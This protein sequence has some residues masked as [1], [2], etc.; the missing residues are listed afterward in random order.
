MFALTREPIDPRRVEAAV[1]DH[2]FGG[3]VAFFGVVRERSSDGRP[4]TGL[5]Y[6][7][8]EPMALAEFAAIARETQRFGEIRLAIVHRLGELRVGD[9]A[10]AV[11]AAS[12]HRDEAFVA[13]RYA[14]DEVKT[15]APIWKKER[16]QSGD[17]VWRE[18]A[19]GSVG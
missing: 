17:D 18:N 3:I 9:I 15:R 14:I 12:A 4:V 19:C 7:A 5:W 2:A 11:V 16:Y 10:V 1:R 8:Y 13:A 6:E